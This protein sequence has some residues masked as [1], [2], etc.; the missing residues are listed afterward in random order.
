MWNNPDYIS[1]K[2][3]KERIQPEWIQHCR[4]KL[5]N[6]PWW[7]T[8]GQHIRNVKIEGLY[9]EGRLAGYLELMDYAQFEKLLSK[10]KY[11]FY[12]SKHWARDRLRNHYKYNR[13]NGKHFQRP[14]YKGKKEVTEHEEAKHEWREFKQ[15]RRDKAKAYPYWCARKSSRVKP[16]IKAHRRYVKQKLAKGD[17]DIEVDYKFSFSDPWDWR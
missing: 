12:Y 4:N 10:N 7:C 6:H 9:H 15:V 5:D 16:A 2:E 11:N 1:E 3:Y 13:N 8:P 17:Y 14:N